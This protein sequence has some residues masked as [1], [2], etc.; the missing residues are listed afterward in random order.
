MFPPSLGDF[1]HCNGRMIALCRCIIHLSLLFCDQASVVFTII[2][3]EM[4]QNVADL[5]ANMTDRGKKE[6]STWIPGGY[7][8]SPEIQAEQT[9]ASGF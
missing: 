5:T 1:L 4:S 3:L 7:T 8:R 9:M 2:L 6:V